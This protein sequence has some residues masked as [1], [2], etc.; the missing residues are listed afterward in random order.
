MEGCILRLM[1]RCLA[2]VGL[3]EVGGGEILLRLGVRGMI[4]CT[5]VILGVDREGSLG[6]DIED[7]EVGDRRIR[8]EGLEGVILSR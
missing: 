3:V 8:L 7:M 5:L 6:R 1:I 2:V 4:L